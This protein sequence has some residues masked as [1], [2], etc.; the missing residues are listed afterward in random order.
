MDGPTNV[1]CHVHNNKF[2]RQRSVTSLCLSVNANR[3][4][5]PL[6]TLEYEFL[7]SS[8]NDCSKLLNAGSKRSGSRRNRNESAPIQLAQCW[9]PELAISNAK[10]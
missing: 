9:F 3:L 1:A 5:K 10:I 8:E 4:V 2:K 7:T 6:V